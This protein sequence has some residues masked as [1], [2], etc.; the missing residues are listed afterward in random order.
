MPFEPAT[1]KALITE[2]GS[3]T[4]YDV[5]EMVE[6]NQPLR[7]IVAYKADSDAIPIARANG[8]TTAMM[9]ALKS[10]GIRRARR[11]TA[12]PV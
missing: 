9:N 5:N 11:Y 8:V 7:A 4:F 2:P 10:C 3:N 6:F 1:V 12:S